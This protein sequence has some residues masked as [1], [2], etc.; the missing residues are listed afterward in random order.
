MDNTRRAEM[1]EELLTLYE[2]RV[3]SH[4]YRMTGNRADTEDLTQE[5][6]MKIYSTM[7]LIRPDKNVKAWIYTIATNTVYDWLRKKQRAP[8]SITL[9][10]VDLA[11]GDTSE[12][13]G[14]EPAYIYT[15]GHIDLER[16]LMQIK[17]A[18]RMVLLLVYTEGL[19]YE[20]IAQVLGVPLNTVKTHIRRAKQSL[21]SYLNN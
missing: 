18:Y 9:D 1:F 10:S 7:A 19:K 2:K 6:F 4:V 16:A 20:E 8:V 15:G 14:D 13:I 3:Y 12:T 5:V 21:K 17:P 11:E